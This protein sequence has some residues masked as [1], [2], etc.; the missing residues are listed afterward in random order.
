MY[1]IRSK[2][3]WLCIAFI[4]FSAIKAP[5]ASAGDYSGGD[6]FA[7]C[8]VSGEEE[9]ESYLY[10]VGESLEDAEVKCLPKTLCEGPYSNEMRGRGTTPLCSPL[11]LN[12][13]L[14]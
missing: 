9:T 3:T 11:G 14:N 2:R 1:F 12:P 13:P 6:E 7:P 8:E 5:T 10:A 4:L